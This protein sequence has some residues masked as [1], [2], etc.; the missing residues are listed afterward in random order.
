MTT[1]RSRSGALARMIV[2]AVASAVA[3]AGCGEVES[4]SADDPTTSSSP[5]SAAPEP[6][7]SVKA[8]RREPT[9]SST[10]TAGQDLPEGYRG[11]FDEDKERWVKPM[12]YRCSSGQQLVTFGRNFYAAKGETI[13]ETSTPLARD[14]NFKKA[15]AACSA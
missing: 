5:T 4:G 2:V 13:N 3:L 12:V 10:W 15:M 11:C 9:C 1:A 7:E 14:K 6:T 8:E